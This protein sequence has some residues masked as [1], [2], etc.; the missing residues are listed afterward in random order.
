MAD[1]NVNDAI[2]I[3]ESLSATMGITRVD[4]IPARIDRSSKTYFAV[5]F[6]S[7]DLTGCEV[8]KAPIT[9]GRLYLQKIKIWTTEELTV[10]LGE[11]EVS[12]SVFRTLIGPIPFN[13]QESGV[14]IAHPATFDYEFLREGI[15]LTNDSDLTID[16]S[17]SGTICGIIEGFSTE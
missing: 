2:T 10:T 14:G 1:T 5:W 6:T 8:I 15:Q 16:A 13:R 7:D 4:L 12:S 3:V 17:L 11:D 9:G